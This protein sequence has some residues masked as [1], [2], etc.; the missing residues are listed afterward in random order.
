MT[1]LNLSGEGITT[2]RPGDLVG[3]HALRTLDLSANALET[4]P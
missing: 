3:L 2:L 4:L 1:D